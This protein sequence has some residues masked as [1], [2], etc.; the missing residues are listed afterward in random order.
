M[1]ILCQRSLS[2]RDNA[3]PSFFDDPPVLCEL[4]ECSIASKDIRAVDAR[5]APLSPT[6]TFNATLPPLALSPLHIQ[7]PVPRRGLRADSSAELR[8]AAA[9]IILQETAPCH[10]D[11]HLITFDHWR[12]WNEN[13]HSASGAESAE[14]ILSPF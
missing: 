7:L 14:S 10:A 9:Q 13:A 11:L 3:S 6:R 12:F 4:R 2:N 8:K 1:Q 5:H